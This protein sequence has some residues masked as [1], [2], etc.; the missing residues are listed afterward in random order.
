MPFPKRP[1]ITINE[2]L[3]PL[4]KIDATSG[5][6]SAVFVGLNAAGGPVDPTVVSSWAEFN[7]LYGGFGVGGDLLPFS[8]F[9]Y[10]NNGGGAAYIIRATN[11]NA[12]VATKTFADTEGA[13]TQTLTVSAKA[14]GLYG[15]SITVDVT[16]GS[17]ANSVS[18]TVTNTKTGMTEVYNDVTLDPVAPRN[19]LSIINGASSL[20]TVSAN[21]PAG[22]FLPTYNPA[23]VA[24][25]SLVGGTDGTG[26]PDLVAAT[27]K[28]ANI[29]GI[30]D[31]NLPG[32][33]DATTINALTTW[34]AT[35]NNVF[36]VV[37]GVKGSATDTAALNQT[38]Q[39]TLVQGFTP[40][41]T[42]AVYGP[43]L[44][45]VDPIGAVAGS[46]RLL[47]PGG[48]VLGQYARTDASRGVQKVA[49]GIDTT[50]NGVIGP[51]FRYTSAQQDTLAPIGLNIIKPIPGAGTCIFG[52]RTLSNGMPDR[53]V[54]IRRTLIALKNGLTEITRFAIFENNDDDLRQQVQDICEQYLRTQWASGMLAGETEDNA[55][56]VVCDDT[57]NT[58][59]TIASGAVN[60]QIG[61]A[62]QT[63]AEFIIFNI[64]QTATGTTTQT[65]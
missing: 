6:P 13:P 56:F 43:W 54:N 12:A 15:N 21:L 17:A 32:V 40:T 19:L 27:Q 55:F 22:A 62:L 60:I 35:Q 26:T 52:A 24:A 37:D 65:V 57:N 50:L 34:A 53:Y 28:I 23:L 16:A 33:N 30:F 44:Q 48:F 10:F 11:A 1:G 7:L 38:A 3:T 9:E 4:P 47:P 64:G 20:V 41:S 5:R 51:Q 49:A 63:P 39:S 25:V 61:L 59:A 8:V 45:A 58:P 18:V 46:P 14:P 2:S 31:I 36:L 29:S 42:A